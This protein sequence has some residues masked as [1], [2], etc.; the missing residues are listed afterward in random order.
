MSRIAIVSNRLPPLDRDEASA[1]GL[2]VGLSAALERS[3]GTWFGWDGT[4]TSEPDDGVR[5]QRSEPFA[6]VSLSLSEREHAGYYIGFANRTLWPLLHGRIDLVHFNPSDFAAYRAVNTRF[7]KTLAAHA[8]SHDLIWVHDYHFLLV[9]QELRRL[10]ISLPMGF[11]LH[12]PFP[13]ADTLAALP[14]HRELIEALSA[15]D[16][17]GFQ[18]DKDVRNFHEFVVRH[19]GGTVSGDG[20]VFALGRRFKT[21]AFPIGIDTRRFAEL[22]ASEEA[23]MLRDRLRGCFHDQVGMIGVDRLDY[24]KGIPYRL[25]AFER[26][27]ETVPRFRMQTFLLQIAAPS[28]ET[29]P[30]YR[31]LKSELEALSG[32][33]NARHATID[34]TPIRYINRTF[35]QMRLAALYRL[36]RVGVITPLCDGMNL[37]AKEYVAAQSAADPGVLVLSCFAGA[38]ERL[39]GALLVNPYDVGGMAKAMQQALEMSLDERRERWSEMIT[40]LRAHDIHGWRDEFIRVLLTTS[41]RLAPES[42]MGRAPLVPL[43]LRV[44]RESSG[45]TAHKA[46]RV[47]FPMRAAPAAG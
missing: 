1:G 27:L 14:C 18:T 8:E 32:R 17:V 34:W 7:A 5:V 25:Q 24:T 38:A 6:V 16:L 4:I 13:A 2:A 9:G 44:V 42:R 23:G 21:G 28:R 47:R 29:I 11:F 30:E 40:E 39:T 31:D 35:S 45:A 43:A 33:I 3:A 10:G 12:I 20:T 37:V 15:F 19:L 22:A 46:A 36:S 41:R 26:M